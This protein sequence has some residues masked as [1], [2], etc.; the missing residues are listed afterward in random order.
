MIQLSLDTLTTLPAFQAAFFAGVVLHLV[1]FRHGEW[2]LYTPHLLAS[3]AIFDGI[4]TFG[5]TRLSGGDSTSMLQSF[6]TVSSLFAVCLGG[7]FTSILV[8]RALFHRLSRFP[9]PFFARL[10]NFYVTSLSVKKFH[11][12]E[13]IKELHEKYGDIVRVGQLENLYT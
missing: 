7:I 9:G 5:L 10:S 6:G 2:D 11:L 3:A 1:A 4:A 8:Y 13:E 12:F